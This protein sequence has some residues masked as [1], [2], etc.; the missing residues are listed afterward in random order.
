LEE[1]GHFKLEGGEFHL[2]DWLSGVKN[3]AP[4][5]CEFR[6]V[7]AGRFAHSAFHTV[8]EHGLAKRTGHSEADSGAAGIVVCPSQAERREERAGMAEPFVIDLAILAPA[9]D[10]DGLGES[11]T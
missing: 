8:A 6:Q 9:E 10:P 5:A 2:E 7:Q 3:D 11:E 1:P 4:R